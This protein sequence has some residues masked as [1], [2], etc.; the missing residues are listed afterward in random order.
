[1]FTCMSLYDS[2]I[3]DMIY[4]AEGA[5]EG[6]FECTRGPIWVHVR[7]D[8]GSREWAVM[9]LQSQAVSAQVT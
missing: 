6:R 9:C 4:D 8:M 3:N 1:M 5:C 7:E 2:D